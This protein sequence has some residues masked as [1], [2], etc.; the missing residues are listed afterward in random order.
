MSRTERALRD[1]LAI[2]HNIGK[3]GPAL[4]HSDEQ[5][6]RE[7]FDTGRAT[8]VLEQE[9]ERIDRA[10]E[11]ESTAHGVAV[12]RECYD[13]EALK[14]ARLRAV[15]AKGDGPRAHWKRVVAALELE[16]AAQ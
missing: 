11:R 1:A 12:L 14:T 13:G 3:S 4:A 10:A 16:A 7:A 2:L 8:G 15:M 9:A 6:A 5:R